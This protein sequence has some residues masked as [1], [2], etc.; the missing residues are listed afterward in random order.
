MDAALVLERKALWNLEELDLSEEITYQ[1]WMTTD[2]CTLL[3]VPETIETFI[4]SLANKVTN[5]TS[6]CC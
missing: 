2:R 1:Q 6:P 4:E 5:K 3:T